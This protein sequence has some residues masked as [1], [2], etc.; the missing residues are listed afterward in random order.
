MR[1]VNKLLGIGLF[2][3]L[4]M[5]MSGCKGKEGTKGPDGKSGGI[6]STAKGQAGAKPTKEA[7]EDFAKAV[8]KYNKLKGDGKID[9]KECE[10]AADAFIQV[11]KEHG[12]PMVAAYFNAGAIYDERG[13]L[14]KAEKIYKDVI[15]ADST[16][17]LAYNNLGVIYWKSGKE[18]QALDT[19]RKGVNANKLQA[20]AARNNVAG[21]SRNAYIK[22]LDTA[23][24][25]EA[26]TSIQTVLALD[27]SNQSAYENLA[28]LY[29][30]RGIRKDPSYLV[31]A[32][33]VVTQALRVL[34][35]EGRKSAD[36]LNISGLLYM[37]RDDQINALKA[38]KGAIEIR[39]DHPEANLNIAFIS[40]RFRDYETAE[41]SLGIALKN[42]N[43][44]KNPEAWLALGVAQRGLKKFDKAEGSYN[45]AAKLAPKDPRPW[46]NLAVLNQMH[47]ATAD[48]I[49]QEGTKKF[50]NVAKKHYAKFMELAGNDKNYATNALEA[51]DSL[52]TIDET[53]EF[54]KIQK[55]LE[56]KAKEME[57][58][59]KK[60]E[61]EERKRLLELEKK[62]QAAAAAG[63]GDAAA[64]GGDGG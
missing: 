43:I 51:K 37:Q 19:F 42:D 35:D 47:L 50:F 21:L 8:A 10:Q 59:Q 53:F 20:R 36:I 11:F 30:D 44:S 54:F 62:A 17:D 18:K 58:L 55:E 2:V 14:E 6:G 13:N 39:P 56:A 33:L 38:F 4:A 1:N 48:G 49:D 34:K 61:A 3:A 24:F 63:G 31:L 12:K 16:Y 9:G 41:K 5:G 40:I 26:E 45:K 7:K 15:N 27:S 46:Y 29:Y 25:N 60:Q 64:G 28:R 23:A 32:N 52:A 22:T 57:A